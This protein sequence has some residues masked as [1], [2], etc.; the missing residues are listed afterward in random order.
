MVHNMT[1][2]AMMRDSPKL[3]YTR[4]TKASCSINSLCSF[5][6]SNMVQSE[7]PT[8]RLFRSKDGSNMVQNP[9]RSG[10]YG[11]IAWLVFRVEHC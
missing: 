9:L 1:A 7:V 11:K 4:V 8:N 3:I 10:L 6:D 5:F 2:F